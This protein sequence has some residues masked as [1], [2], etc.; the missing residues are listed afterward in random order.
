[1]NLFGVRLVQARKKS[2][3]YC[4]SRKN[5]LAKLVMT[6]NGYVRLSHII[7]QVFKIKYDKTLRLSFKPIFS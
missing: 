3:G 6:L 7:T 4:C 5:I 2:T 1:M